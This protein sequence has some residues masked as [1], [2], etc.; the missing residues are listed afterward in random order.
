MG[1]LIGIIQLEELVHQTV[2]LPFTQPLVSLYSRL[3]GHGSQPVRDDR[4]VRL[5]APLLDLVQELDKEILSSGAWATVVFR[6]QELDRSKG[7]YGPEKYS[8]RRYQKRDGQYLPKSKFNI[9]SAA[10]ARKLIEILARWTEG[11]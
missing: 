11:A 6:Y 4:Q 5:T 2:H 9:S 3:A 8:I 10:Q 1:A 7:E